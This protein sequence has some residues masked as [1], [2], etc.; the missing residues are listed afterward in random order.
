LH[1]YIPSI[2][3]SIGLFKAL[4]PWLERA[5]LLAGKLL[6]FYI[7]KHPGLRVK[8]A[9]VFCLIGQSNEWHSKKNS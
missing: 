7:S 9:Q 4:F 6:S 1:P 5:L 2:R 8:E 3:M